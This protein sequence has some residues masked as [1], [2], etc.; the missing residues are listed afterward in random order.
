MKF[1]KSLT[2][3]DEFAYA[4][5]EEDLNSKHNHMREE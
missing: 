5:N 2:N 4:K 1:T 3:M